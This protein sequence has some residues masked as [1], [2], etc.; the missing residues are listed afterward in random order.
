M[1]IH[2]NLYEEWLIDDLCAKYGVGTKKVLNQHS[3]SPLVTACMRKVGGIVAYCCYKTHTPLHLRTDIN[4]GAVLRQRLYNGI[5]QKRAIK[6]SRASE[7][8]LLILYF[9]EQRYGTAFWKELKNILR[10]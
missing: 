9:M 4:G 5:V 10:K 6:Y 3:G 2:Q 7:Q 1:R 8:T